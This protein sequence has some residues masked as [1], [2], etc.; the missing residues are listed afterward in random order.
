MGEPTAK[1]FWVSRDSSAFPSGGLIAGRT[2]YGWAG[3]VYD[4]T[5]DG[6]AAVRRRFLWQ[7]GWALVVSGIVSL[8]FM[9]YSPFDTPQAVAFFSLLGVVLIMCGF[10]SVSLIDREP[11]IDAHLVLRGG[12]WLAK[13]R[14]LGPDE[15]DD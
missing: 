11:T 12:R 14:R 13:L 8:M 5:R 9:A 15:E 10:R 6:V 2:V 4:H 7:A 3:L 1:S